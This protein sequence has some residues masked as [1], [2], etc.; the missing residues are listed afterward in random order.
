MPYK[1]APQAKHVNL[2]GVVDEQ[3]TLSKVGV[4]FKEFP[5]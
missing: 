4:M 1:G 2:M 3:V 5:I